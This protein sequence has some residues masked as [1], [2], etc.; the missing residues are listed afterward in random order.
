MKILNNIKLLN[1]F[2]ILLIILVILFT[3]SIT[4]V[5]A[6]QFTYY[7]KD[8]YTNASLNQTTFIRSEVN[9]INNIY[10]NQNTGINNYVYDDL[11]N[12]YYDLIMYRSCYV[13]TYKN[14]FLINDPNYTPQYT[15]NLKKRT[16][17]VNV[18]NPTV[19]SSSYIVDNVVT[20]T[21]KITSWTENYVP[22]VP[23]DIYDLDNT[24]IFN[25]YYSNGSLAYTSGEITVTI[26]TK[27]D[28]NGTI[29]KD[30]VAEITT[31]W[32]PSIADKYK[33]EVIG[34]LDDCS[35][36]ESA[37][38]SAFNYLN[39]YETAEGFRI[40]EVS[41]NPETIYPNIPTWGDTSTISATVSTQDVK[42][43]ITIREKNEYGNIVQTFSSTSL[44]YAIVQLWDGTDNSGTVVSTNTYYIN[45]TATDSNN[46]TASGSNWVYVDSR[47]ADSTPP[48][49]DIITPTINEIISN[50]RQEIKV[51]IT[52]QGFGINWSTL[53]LTLDSTTKTMITSGNYASYTPSENLSDETHNIEIRV[54]DYFGNPTVTSWSFYV[55]TEAPIITNSN[56]SPNP[57]RLGNTVTVTATITDL[58][59]VD[60]VYTKINGIAG[61]ITM[62]KAGDIY[63]GTFTTP[64]IP[65]E[66]TI[67]IIANDTLGNIAKDAITLE[68]RSKPD[69]HISAFESNIPS[70]VSEGLIIN[71]IAHVVN[72]GDEVLN[73]QI[74]LWD[75]L[76][77]IAT[78]DIT[79]N[80]ISSEEIIFNYD[81]LGKL[82]IHN[83]KV[84]V[85]PT[86]SIYES[87][88]TNNEKYLELEIR[89]TTPPQILTFTPTEDQHVNTFNLGA[90]TNE[91]ATC[92]YDT[93]DTDY[94]AM[95]NTFTT[96]GTTI[97]TQEL[98]LTD[99]AYT[100]YTRCQ[101]NYGNSNQESNMTSFTIDTKP[102]IK[103]STD[104]ITINQTDRFNISINLENY[105]YSTAEGILTITIP[106]RLTLISGNTTDNISIIVGYNNTYEL[107][108]EATWWGDY[109][110][111]IEADYN[112]QIKTS[113]IYVQSTPI[114]IYEFR[115]ASPEELVENDT[116][117]VAIGIYNKGIVNGN[118]AT[119]NISTTSNLAI[120]G[121]SSKEIT[122]IYANTT[123]QNASWIDF[124]IKGISSGTGTIYITVD[125]I[126]QEKTITVKNTHL[127]IDLSV[128]SIAPFN[129]SLGRSFLVTAVIYNTGNSTSLAT[130]A[131]IALE[132]GL[133][134]SSTNPVLL[135]DIEPTVNGIPPIR[136]EWIINST[137]SGPKQI[138][139]T[140]ISLFEPEYNAS[141][142]VMINILDLPE[143]VQPFITIESDVNKTILYGT[144]FNITAKINN[145]GTD[146]SIN[147]KAQLS[148]VDGLEFI[149]T[150]TIDI[151]ILEI[152]QETTITWTLN[153]TTTGTFN[154]QITITEIE[155]QFSDKT[156][157]DI[158]YAHDVRINSF[159]APT[160]ANTGNTIVI[161][162]V[163]ENAGLYDENG[164]NVTLSIN[165]HI[166]TT[167]TYN[168][169]SGN[170][171]GVEFGWTAS[172]GTHTLKLSAYIPYDQNTSNNNLSGTIT[173][174]TETNNGGGSS[175]RSGS[176]RS[177]TIIIVN[178]TNT[179]TTDENVAT[180]YIS[181]IELSDSLYIGQTMTLKG[182]L[183]N[184]KS[185]TVDLVI[186]YKIVKTQELDENDC[187]SITYKIENL[188]TGTHNIAIK[189]GEAT[190][191]SKD[192]LIYQYVLTDYKEDKE[193]TNVTVINGPTG[194]ILSTIGSSNLIIYLLILLII[195][196]VYFKRE[197]IRTIVIKK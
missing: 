113:K 158:R 57:V 49:I 114:P 53:E 78:K 70:P 107:E 141:E 73:T 37:Q 25:V 171:T 52:D 68:V 38:D 6:E 139:M 99:G 150:Q 174:T 179:E 160:S 97:H 153:A 196:A 156:N 45:I 61:T 63:T 5:S 81:T 36:I 41:A 164:I 51:K 127:Y 85:D 24:V 117:Q 170:T 146:A 142:S 155:H 186:D 58:N 136:Q 173:V 102:Y 16:C 47:E 64:E 120:V 94:S 66:Y 128:S 92:K 134:T 48:N 31:E 111:N 167:K 121:S 181:E 143:P 56:L 95:A 72:G 74:Q 10:F 123:E 172:E 161:S 83:F 43:T 21:D 194:N 132:T 176:S 178:E 133:E 118:N 13:P 175:S 82:G 30:G 195:I 3:A 15:I 100:F 182:C 157:F 17:T 110:I 93:I 90:T 44:D 22:G 187:F 2:N 19:K 190:L 144:T 126:T 69:L 162:G 86:N 32:S 46:N 159:N 177:S 59:A 65:T 154:P 189:Q 80:T 50:P 122:T 129:I 29:I 166:I 42:Y 140:I 119:I 163:L 23:L 115:I 62:N 9:N 14:N 1:R 112:N 108:L 165:G 60:T 105:G 67:M 27:K 152:N 125:G 84:I 55:D 145:I 11:D 169:A 40:Y 192:V 34:L 180:T 12:G 20:F 149:T 71:L 185:N 104:N 191:Y 116:T 54:K 87:N 77:L 184:P 193:Q 147:T 89:D 76:V 197:K 4:L 101:D 7:A 130:K 124:E 168:L 135:G 91:N 33:Y 131:E 103:I 183:T 96:T 151:D 138:N 98:T 109:V 188:A 28:S 39:I 148:G 26:P 79:I 18:E 75:N 88:E 137:S 106:E 35:C 8:F